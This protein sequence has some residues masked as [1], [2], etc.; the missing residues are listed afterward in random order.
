MLTVDDDRLDNFS[1]EYNLK[2]YA[3][4][5]Q[6]NN[7][8]SS[9]SMNESIKNPSEEI[10]I[11][12]NNEVLSFNISNDSNEQINKINVDIDN[13]E[14]SENINKEILYVYHFSEEQT[15]NAL[16]LLQNDKYKVEDHVFDQWEMTLIPPLAEK[17]IQKNGL[18]H[19]LI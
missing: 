13:L 9:I 5:I 14:E 4:E 3:S 11:N 1:I 16:N 12:K 7:L 15:V 19:R 6:N 8:T 17:F 2:N 10:K 18:L